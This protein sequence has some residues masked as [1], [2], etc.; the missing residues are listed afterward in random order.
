MSVFREYDVRGIAD[1]DLTDPFVY[2]LGR[3]LGDLLRKRGDSACYVGQDVRVSSPRLVKALSAGL[4]AADIAVRVIAPGPT[5]LTYYLASGGFDGKGD[6]EFPSKSGIMI[7]GSHNPGEYNGFKMVI[8]GTTLHGPDIQALQAP[9]EKYQAQAPSDMSA[10]PE[11]IDYHSKYVKEIQGTLNVSR[12]LHVVVDAG[13]GAG[14]RLGVEFYEALGCQVTPL[15]CTPDGTFPNHHPDPTVPKN[16]EQLIAK[17]KEVGADVGIAFDGDADRIGAVSATGRILFGDQLVLYYARDI[18]KE[19]PHA[20]IISEV[21]SSQVLYDTLAE[22]GAKPIIWK[23]GHSLIKAKLKETH[24]ALAGEMSGHMF[25]AH[26]FLGFD[27][28][29]YAGGRLLE[30]MS[31]HPNETLDQFLDSLPPAINTP[32]LRVDTED[33]KKFGIVDEFIKKAKALYGDDVLDIDGARVKMHGGWGLIRA[34]NT[35]PV[36]VLRFEAPNREL[37]GK[38]RDEFAGLLKDIDSS[39]VVPEA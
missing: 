6:P 29:I 20:T 1:R 24:A 30:G 16:L 31:Q 27:D 11:A 14:W 18:L 19:I 21:K 37:L 36:L 25:F 33:D 7:T 3:A 5:P 2:G 35:Q 26:R 10:A 8:A 15:F 23:T 28:A 39:V 4:Q 12:P 9:T 22:W 17:V 13:N 32:E 38:I 34:S